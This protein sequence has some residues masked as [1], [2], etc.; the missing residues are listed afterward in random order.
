GVVLEE[1][2]PEHLGDV[3]HAHGHPGVPGIGALHGVHRE[4]ADAVGELTACG[5]TALCA[6]RRPR[7]ARARSLTAVR[8]APR[9]TKCTGNDSLSIRRRRGSIASC[10]AAPVPPRLCAGREADLPCGGAARPSMWT[11]VS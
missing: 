6:A 3:G 2:T 5:H 8:S 7:A 4:S 9:V 10:A 1:V 11:T